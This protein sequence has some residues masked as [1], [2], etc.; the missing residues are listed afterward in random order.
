MSFKV[1]SINPI[2][3]GNVKNVEDAT[4]FCL[5]SNHDKISRLF[6][7]EFVKSHYQDGDMILVEN[8]VFSEDVNIHKTEGIPDDGKSYQAEGWEPPS[9]KEISTYG[10]KW[11]E[12]ILTTRKNILQGENPDHIPQSSNFF[13][14]LITFHQESIDV[15]ML[16]KELKD[17]YIQFLSKLKNLIEKKRNQELNLGSDHSDIVLSYVKEM[18]YCLENLYDLLTPYGF[19]LSKND[20]KDF[21]MELASFIAISSPSKEHFDRMILLFIR[22]PESIIRIAN[23]D[24]RDIFLANLIQNYLQ[25]FAEKGK[26]QRLFVIGGGAHIRPLKATRKPKSYEVLK[27]HSKT[28]ICMP[29]EFHASIIPLDGSRIHPIKKC[30]IPLK[31][32]DK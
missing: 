4:L 29:S 30:K 7:E 32:G 25:K 19:P 31:L 12:M 9:M 2:Y 23:L 27:N 13:I 24:E 21:I 11:S 20:I 8:I 26:K 22:I 17:G 10:G 18:Y 15:L 3:Y 16:N 14:N 5:P 1:G 6:I 28:V